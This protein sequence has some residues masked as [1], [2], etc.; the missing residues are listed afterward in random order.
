MVW[1][2]QAGVSRG[3]NVAGKSSQCHKYGNQDHPC[4]LRHTCSTIVGLNCSES[5][6]SLPTMNILVKKRDL[7]ASGVSLVEENDAEKSSQRHKY[8]NPRPPMPLRAHME[9][10]GGVELLRT[11]QFPSYHEYFGIF[12]QKRWFECLWRRKCR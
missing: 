2:P 10:Y 1:V 4:T 6:H 5:D 11:R 9:H 8:G 7:G 3:G 12:S